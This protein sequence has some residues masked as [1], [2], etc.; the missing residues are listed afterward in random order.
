MIVLLKII[1]YVIVYYKFKENTKKK[2]Y[3]ISYHTITLNYT[4]LVSICLFYSALIYYSIFFLQQNK[5]RLHFYL[6]YDIISLVLI[7]RCVGMADDADSKSVVVTHV[8]VQV[9]PP[10]FDLRC[11]ISR[12]FFYII[13]NSV[14]TSY[15]IKKLLRRMRTSRQGE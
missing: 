12:I 13:G 10:A 4:I 11:D 9:P 15:Y 8:R 14:G 1:T 5:N 6:I 2:R 3:C 7:S